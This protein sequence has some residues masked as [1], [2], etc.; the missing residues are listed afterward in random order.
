M[1]DGK[2]VFAGGYATGHDTAKLAPVYT[3]DSVTVNVNGGTWGIATAPCGGRGIFGGAF[4]GDNLGT[5]GVYAQVGNVDMTISGGTMGNVYGGGW[6]QKGAKSEV[7]D[8]SIT[9]KGGTMAN[10]FG[11]GS[12]STS[13]GSTV[14]GN[15]TITVSGGTI[16]GDICAMGQSATDSV[17]NAEV[18]FTGKNDFSCG[19]YGYTY[20]GSAV[21][22]ATL[23]FSDYTGTFSGAIGGFADVSV[24]KNSWMTLGTAADD[25][26]NTAWTF[27]F[28]ERDLGL[29]G[30]A[31]LTW[32]T[33]DF[34]DDTIT[35][36][37]ASTRSEGWTLVSG[38]AADKYNTAADAFVVEI[39]GTAT[40]LTFDSATGKTDTI[41]DGD[42]AGWGFAVEDSVLKFTKLA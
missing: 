13:G 5:D 9:I 11:G 30:N 12:T 25:V 3:V 22:D 39:D 15:V 16:T 19:V 14:A 34:S 32:T 4:A 35:L 24:E 37:I 1:D 7:G 28:A 27:D 29:D 2:C 38:A 23:T 17:T 21:S 8:V 36:K 42:Y 10:V 20:V 26:S 40:S 31:A 41:A 33:A 18:I 6:A